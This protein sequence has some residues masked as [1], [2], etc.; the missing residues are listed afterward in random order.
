VGGKGRFYSYRTVLFMIY[1]RMAI[2]T[3]RPNFVLLT[4]EGLDQHSSGYF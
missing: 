1:Y 3:R 4:L 2:I